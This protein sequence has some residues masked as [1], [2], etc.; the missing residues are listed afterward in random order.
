MSSIDEERGA[1]REFRRNI[2]RTLDAIDKRQD[3][4]DDRMDRQDVRQSSSER[5]TR[6]LLLTILAAVLGIVA[7][8]LRG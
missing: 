1:G 3:R 8:L 4:Q 5:Q 6:N 2:V 7:A